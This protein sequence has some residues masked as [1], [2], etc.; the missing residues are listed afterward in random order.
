M[1]N[2]QL[3]TQKRQQ[4]ATNAT[5]QKALNTCMACEMDYLFTQVFS[6]VK[7]PFTPHHFLHAIW[8]YANYFAGYEQQDA[9]EFL[10]FL[11]NAI[12]NDCGGEICIIV[13]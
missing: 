4:N 6:G 8:K 9:H 1:H 7:T 10:I 12:H 5:T 2:R 13:R 3:C 11:L